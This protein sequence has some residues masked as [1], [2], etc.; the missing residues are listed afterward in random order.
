MAVTGGPTEDCVDVTDTAKDTES[1]PSNMPAV[2]D[3]GMS[4]G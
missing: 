1:C 4:S 2:K 3:E